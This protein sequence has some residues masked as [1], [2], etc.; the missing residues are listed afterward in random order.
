MASRWNFLARLTSRRQDKGEHE[1]STDEGSPQAPSSTELSEP[2]DDN[3]SNPP[4]GSIP[5]E[6]KSADRHDATSA[7]LAQPAELGNDVQGANNVDSAGFEPTVNP[8]PS[9]D[10]DTAV[11]ILNDVGSPSQVAQ[12]TTRKVRGSRKTARESDVVAQ[13]SP[14]IPTYLEEQ[15]SLEDEIKT[16]REQLSRRLQLQNAQLKKMLERFER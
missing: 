10:I 14:A 3:A 16:L 6:I 2:A 9:S 5:A 4:D 11:T 13:T 15:L 12:G 1:T 8:I 7:G